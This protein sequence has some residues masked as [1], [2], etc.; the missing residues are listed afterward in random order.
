[1]AGERLVD[2]RK[3]CS[4][5]RLTLSTQGRPS[6]YNSSSPR[7]ACTSRRAC[8]WQPT[9]MARRRR[10]PLPGNC[11]NTERL[12]ERV[13]LFTRAARTC[14]GVRANTG[15]GVKRSLGLCCTQSTASTRPCSRARSPRLL[16]IPVH[17]APSRGL[18]LRAQTMRWNTPKYNSS[19]L[20]RS[21]LRPWAR[22]SMRSNCWCRKA[23]AWRT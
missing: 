21:R 11:S 7:L 18:C 1:M 9:P 4:P 16:T 8:T 5:A 17:W 10:M 15:T 19:S 13:G 22:S 3:V 12:L 23:Q 20:A 2:S 6:T 14:S